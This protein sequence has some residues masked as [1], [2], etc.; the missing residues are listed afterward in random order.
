MITSVRMTLMS[1]RRKTLSMRMTLCLI[2][3]S[4][5]K[6]KEKTSAGRRGKRSY[7]RKRLSCQRKTVRMRRNGRRSRMIFGRVSCPMSDQ[8]PK[9]R[10]LAASQIPLR[11]LNVQ[12]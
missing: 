6:R 11:R 5:R 1:V 8:D 9:T 2:L 12:H 4:R 3:T 7:S 10:H